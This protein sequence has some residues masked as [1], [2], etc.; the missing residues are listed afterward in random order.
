LLI[1]AS[2]SPRRAEILSALGIPFRVVPASVDE[3]IRPGESALAAAS[4][5][6]LEKASEVSSRH[7]EDWVLAA[8]TLVFFPDGRI[9]G[10]PADDREAAAMLRQLSGREHEVVT[11]TRL[12]RGTDAGREALEVSAV[13]IASLSDA[14]V[15]WYVAT[16]EPR[17]KAGA[18]AVQGKGARFI[19]SISGSYSN[20]M[21]LPAR[22]VYDLIRA[23]PD[24]ALSALALA[25][26]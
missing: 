10:K 23:A 15:A 9:L 12:R 21:G 16:G 17:D 8:D 24:P 26:P 2:S 20:V 11:A 4:R 13:R 25:S 6:A 18:Y 5:L 1:L 7:P 22:A 3:T 19:E 14:E